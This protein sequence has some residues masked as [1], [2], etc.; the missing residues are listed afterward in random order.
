MVAYVSGIDMG[1]SSYSSYR[2]HTHKCIDGELLAHH[3]AH[4]EG[5]VFIRQGAF[6]NIFTLP[7]PSCVAL[8]YHRIRRLN[9]IHSVVTLPNY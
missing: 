5:M 4:T 3:I 7:L 6:K 9:V 1:G 8:G 2:L